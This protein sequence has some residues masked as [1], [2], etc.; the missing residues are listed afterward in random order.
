MIVLQYSDVEL[1]GEIIHLEQFSTN[2]QFLS[3][4]NKNLDLYLTLNSCIS[5]TIVCLGVFGSDTTLV[6]LL[7]CGLN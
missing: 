5:N 7:S 6:Q 2:W 1:C 3:T 4:G